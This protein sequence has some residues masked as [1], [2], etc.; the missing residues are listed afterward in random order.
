MDVAFDLGGIPSSA[1]VAFTGGVGALT[2]PVTN[3]DEDTGGTSVT[4]TLTG[5]NATGETIVISSAAPS[6]TGTVT[7]DDNM[8]TLERGA[9]IFGVNAG[10]RTTPVTDESGNTYDVPVGSEWVFNGQSGAPAGNDVDYTGDGVDNE[11]DTVYET[12]YWGGSGTGELSFTRDGIPAGDYILVIKL[13]EIFANADMAGERVF[14]VTVNG[15]TV[16]DD[17]D[18][19]DTAGQFVAYDVDIPVT[20]TDDGAGTGTLRVE[21][22]PSVDNA[23]FSALAL[24]EAVEVD[25]AAADVSVA[26]VTVSEEAGLAEVVFTREGNT[27]TDMTI[28]FSTGDGSATAGEDYTAATAQSVTILAGAT[29]ATAQIALTGDVLDEGDETFTVTIDFGRGRRRQCHRHA[30]RGHRDPDRR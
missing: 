25:P 11:D 21:G 17:L 1:T 9:F 12:E 15:V 30:A 23:K 14:D 6:A 29:T 24:F 16:I 20:I 18:L 3:D 7:E 4:I 5:A 2:I 19:V 26:D 22:I 27:D 8:P 10:A 13:A 28:T